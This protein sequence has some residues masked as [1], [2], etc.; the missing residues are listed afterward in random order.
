MI[1]LEINLQ[2]KQK[3]FKE[4]IEKYPVTLFG[5]AKGGGKSKGLR[6]I[7]LLRRFQYAGSHGAIFRR[8]Y[9][10]LEGNHIRPLLEEFPALQK[11]WNSSKKLL[12]LPNGSTLQFCH[13][14]NESDISLYQGR[15]FHDLAIDEAGQWTE[16]MF[17]KL[18]GSN[19]SSKEGIEAKTIL[20]GNPGGPGHKWLKRLFIERRFNERERPNDYAF[21]QALVDDNPALL[22]I[23]PDY[24]HRLESEPNEALRKAYRH[25]SWDIFAGQFFNEISRDVH[26]IK[27]MPIPRHWNRFGA[28]DYG[29]NHPAA[30]G[31]FV[32][33][34]DGNVIQYR[35]LVQAGLRVDQFAERV[36]QYPD[37]TQLQSIVA[38]HDCW[39][40]KA[41]INRGSTPTIAEEF[42][43]HNLILTR[44]KI[45]RVQGASQV[46]NYLA[47]RD[48]KNGNSSP[49]FTMFDSCPISFDALTRMEHDPDH[50]ED[51]LK[52]DALEGDPMS[53]DDAYD[54]VRYALM[55]R[56]L[57]SQAERIKH[58]P[59]SSEWA[60][61]E[62]ERMEQ[63][64]Q[65]QIERGEAQGRGEDM[66]N[67][68]GLPEDDVLRYYINKRR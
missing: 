50:V 60:Q 61:Q 47:W 1:D 42:L 52:I 34:E 32:V 41:M 29:F 68:I 63:R 59:G 22:S 43:K 13:C 18:Q 66:D 30:F 14:N 49:R 20:T 26:L 44:A 15:E 16:S 28:Y 35:E 65:E 3:L 21:I 55:S 37:T 62:V 12:T 33:D 54:M 17:R 64:L 23:D 51:V 56:P 31:W 6:L 46:R 25:G 39:A 7:L 5:G 36:N 19:R 57:I 40:K 58:A 8:T 9:P 4:Y 11:Y 10:E 2:P 48:L 53:G 27:S 67:T 24:V 45:D 38:G